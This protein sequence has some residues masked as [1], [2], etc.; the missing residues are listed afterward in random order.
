M[1]RP[2]SVGVDISDSSIKVLQLN[3]EGN[4]VAYGSGQSPEGVVRDGFIHDKELFA[5]T[6]TQILKDTKPVSLFAKQSL[7]RAVLCLPESKLFTHSTKL[8]EHIK[9]GDIE[10]FVREDSKKIIPFNLEEMYWDYHVSEKNG[11]RHVTFVG[12]PKANVDN[13]VEAFTFAEVKP[14]LIVG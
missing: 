7:L 6:L 12:A 8:P 11:E 3:E 5:T 2:S 10:E 13:Y 1:R 14:S 4:V 9:G